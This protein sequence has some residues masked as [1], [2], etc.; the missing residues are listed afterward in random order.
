M[1]SSS[2]EYTVNLTGER[3]KR[4]EMPPTHHQ[5]RQLNRSVVTPVWWDTRQENG[6]WCQAKVTPPDLLSTGPMHCFSA[7]PTRT[8]QQ[9][10]TPTPMPNRSMQ[11]RRLRIV[12]LQAGF[13]SIDFRFQIM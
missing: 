6:H 8:V 13:H 3:R 9:N 12:P 1:C 5:T 4:E 2:L 7:I 10:W 11:T